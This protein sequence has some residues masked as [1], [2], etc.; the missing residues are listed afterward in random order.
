MWKSFWSFQKS[1]LQPCLVPIFSLMLL[2]K[3]RSPQLKKV[4]AKN[5]K[6]PQRYFNVVLFFFAWT[7][8]NLRFASESVRKSM[9]QLFVCGCAFLF[10]LF[11]GF[12]WTSPKRLITK[13]Q[14]IAKMTKSVKLKTI[15]KLSAK[16]WLPKTR[17]DFFELLLSIFDYVQLT[18][19]TR[20]SAFQIYIQNFTL[21][22]RKEAIWKKWKK[23]IQ[24]AHVKW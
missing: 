17:K 16:V 9:Q 13:R 6:R 8:R 10:T 19:E 22:F 7:D 3:K 2:R 11:C 5:K 24:W 1:I 15:I 4:K 23:L 14:M 20:W 18:I 21:Y 12:K